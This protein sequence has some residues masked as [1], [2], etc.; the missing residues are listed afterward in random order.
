MYSAY[1]LET[2]ETEHACAP[3]FLKELDLKSGC[4]VTIPDPIYQEEILK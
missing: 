2:V 3:N 1:G 4:F